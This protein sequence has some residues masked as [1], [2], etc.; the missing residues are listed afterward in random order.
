MA[1]F[2]VTRRAEEDIAEIMEYIA[3]DNDRAAMIFYERQL[4]L[5]RMLAGYPEAGRVRSELGEGLRSFPDGNYLIFYR[6]WAGK[7]SIARVLH[8]AR[9]L[10]EIFS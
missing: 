3:A 10:D 1:R 7:I 6:R 8:S 4:E 2:I 9:D 5:F